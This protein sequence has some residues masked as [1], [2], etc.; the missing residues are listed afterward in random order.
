M[1]PPIMECW[2]SQMHKSSRRPW[3]STD[4]KPEQ[5]YWPNEAVGIGS[6]EVSLC[7]KQSVLSTPEMC[8]WAGSISD[9]GV[10]A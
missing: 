6:I 1:I 7:A 10:E 2:R 5:D 4:V 9:A 8:A 3:H